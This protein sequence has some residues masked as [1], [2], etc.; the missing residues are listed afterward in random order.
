[1]DILTAINERV[2]CPR[3]QEPPPDAAQLEQLL[4]AAV[5]APDHGL[6]RP[7]RFITVA[8][9]DRQRF[10]Q[11]V[12]DACIAGQPDLNEAQ[13]EKLRLAP[14]RA[15]M[16]LVV[17]AEIQVE[18]KVSEIDQIMAC[19]AAVQNLLLTAH[20][21]GVGAMWR[22]GAPA[23]SNEL[24]VALGFSPKDEIVGFIYLG[25]PCGSPRVPSMDDPAPYVRQLPHV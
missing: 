15:P 10:G 17:V 2:S 25:T 13:C 12:V 11:M 18:H 7:W 19:A 21:I 9:E 4:K 16:V 23:L 3:L 24:K 20:A 1:M 8:G 14:L 6:L 5:R 22:T